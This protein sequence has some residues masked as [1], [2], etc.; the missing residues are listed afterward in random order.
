HSDGRAITTLQKDDFQLYED[1]SLRDIRNFASADAPYSVLAMFDCTGSLG[2]QWEFLSDALLGFT[3]KIRAQGSIRVA[4]FGSDLV[5]W[6][7]G[8][9]AVELLLN[10]KMPRPVQ[11]P[12]CNDTDFYGAMRSASSWIGA[13]PMPRKGVIV[14]TDGVH[15]HIPRRLVKVGGL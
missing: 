13:A 3:R 10:F 14:F 1:G 4:A 8:V 12:A 15:E 7:S 11:N 2:D 6:R 5:L 9:H